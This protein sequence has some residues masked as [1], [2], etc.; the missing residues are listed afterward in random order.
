MEYHRYQKYIHFDLFYVHVLQ[1]Q[2]FKNTSALQL[3]FS[4]LFKEE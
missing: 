2:R 1:T 3:F 4:V